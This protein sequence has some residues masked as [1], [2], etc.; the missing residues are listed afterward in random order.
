[1]YYI[2]I[3]VIKTHLN[4]DKDYCDEDEYLMMLA[5]VAIRSVEN[6]I[7]QPIDK[8]I[9]GDGELESPLM[10]AALLLVGTLYQNRESVAFGQSFKIP[11]AYEY[12]IQP[13][14]NY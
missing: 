2:D 5:D 8:F 14:V 9:D 7:D 6:Y 10:H 3:D 12:L 1:M 4:I 11:H 13:Y